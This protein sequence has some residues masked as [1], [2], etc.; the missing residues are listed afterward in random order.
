[1]KKGLI[2]GAAATAALAAMPMAGVFAANVTDTVELTVNTACTM[3]A[4]GSTGTSVDLG[5]TAPGAALTEQ[6]GTVM[7]VTC[8]NADGW[9][10]SAAVESLSFSGASR[11]IPFGAY[12]TSSSVWSAKVALGTAGAATI[13]TG[14][15]NYGASA[16]G[17]IVTGA[18]GS[19]V[20]GL[21]ITPSYKAYV[22]AAQPAG[23][24]S[25]TI[26]YTFSQL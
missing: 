9:T 16:G 21:T 14:W 3:T 11:P 25:G 17:V 13:A 24:Y 20:S 1:M 15:D 4:G 8:N 23:T 22:D 6:N 10:L 19:G 12:G 7:T 5:D 18:A 2:A 26:A